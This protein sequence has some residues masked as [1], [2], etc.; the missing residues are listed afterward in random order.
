MEVT[1]ENLL[2]RRIKV[3]Y[4]IQYFLLTNTPFSVIPVQN[5]EILFKNEVFPA[6]MVD[7]GLEMSIF[8]TILL[9][10]DG[11]LLNFEGRTVE[12]ELS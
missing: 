3:V 8:E 4:L 9:K 2:I 7:F 12:I 10:S 11:I 5:G 1:H 6:K